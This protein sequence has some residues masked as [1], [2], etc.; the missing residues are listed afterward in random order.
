MDDSPYMRLRE[1]RNNNQ[2]YAKKTSQG[3]LSRA[4]EMREREQREM[5]RQASLDA[6][7]EE[8]IR[9][10]PVSES[11]RMFSHTDARTTE[12]ANRWRDAIAEVSRQNKEDMLQR[13]FD[14]MTANRSAQ[15][16]CPSI[17]SN[18]VDKVAGKKLSRGSSVSDGDASD[19]D[20]SKGGKEGYNGRQ[21]GFSLARI[22]VLLTTAVALLKKISETAIK[23]AEETLNRGLTSVELGITEA[24]VRGYNLFDVSHGLAQ[25]TTTGAL[26]S[27]S[28]MFMDITKLDEKGLMGI[29]TALGA[30]P[31]VGGDLGSLIQTSF[32]AKSINESFKDIINGFFGMYKNR[33][34][35]LGMPVDEATSASSLTQF[36]RDYLGDDFANLFA[37]M[38]LADRDGSYGSFNSFEEL[39]SSAK[40]QRVSDETIEYL[41]ATAVELNK[42]RA[43]FQVLADALSVEFFSK[44]SG[45]IDWV[46]GVSE[47]LA[48]DEA[49]KAGANWTN[50]EWNE[51]R[52]RAIE[53]KNKTLGEALTAYALDNGIEGF[54]LDTFN[55]VRGYDLSNGLTELPDSVGELLARFIKKASRNGDAGKDALYSLF[56]Y[57]NSEAAVDRLRAEN[58][59]KNPNKL[60]LLSSDE[61][62]TQ[63][64]IDDYKQA[65]LANDAILEY[66]DSIGGIN[67]KSINNY[68][69]YDAA[70]SQTA[71]SRFLP[72]LQPDVYKEL[73]AVADDYMNRGH[74]N[75]EINDAVYAFMKEMGI[76]SKEEQESRFKDFL[77]V[78]LAQALF[79]RKSTSALKNRVMDLVKS[80]YDDSVTYSFSGD[81]EPYSQQRN[82]IE[83]STAKYEIEKLFAADVG[84]YIS[85]NFGAYI[86]NRGWKASENSSERVITEENGK[87]HL[88]TNVYVTTDA[89]KVE[90]R[91]IEAEY[92]VSGNRMEFATNF[93]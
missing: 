80:G 75:K 48:L 57:L 22:L 18:N 77:P 66:L 21:R 28:S 3:L 68:W 44:F 69:D 37:H 62:I 5:E 29:A 90:K 88:T 27:L 8:Q 67:R 85:D 47:R 23:Q 78:A 87:I 76:S 65:S 55:N 50:A 93:N 16:A 33:Q 64:A 46:E 71:F 81:A 45:L 70:N 4:T 63:G 82:L 14:R 15:S 60:E 35:Y 42:I 20:T 51:E 1:R 13:E 84:K 7:K 43:N 9:K 54:D 30:D 52:A 25:G 92:D 40:I 58:R 41:K 38:V 36:I 12:Y 26:K 74:N 34:N 89:G 91:T 17:S 53:G 32:G 61:Q 10:R 11:A 19:D 59:R 73:L 24:Q 56:Y 72:M 79:S 6:W 49:G 39:Y 83:G 2:Y 31:S 86:K